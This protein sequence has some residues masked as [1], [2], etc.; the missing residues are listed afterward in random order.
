MLAQ[1]DIADDSQSESEAE[2]K[3][4]RFNDAQ[5]GQLFLLG[6][7]F[8]NPTDE[9]RFFVDDLDILHK[10]AGY[11]IW[12]RQ[13]SEAYDVYRKILD[14]WDHKSGRR[15]ETLDAMVHCAMR[16]GLRLQVKEALAA[17]KDDVSSL[18]DQVN[19]WTTTVAVAEYDADIVPDSEH[20]TNIVYLCTLAEC[21]RHWVMF[22][23]VSD[24]ILSKTSNFRIGAKVRAF[25]LL[26]HEH[27][28]I[29]T[30]S[31]STERLIETL[32]LKL[33]KDLQ[34][35]YTEQ[36]ITT[37]CDNICTDIIKTKDAKETDHSTEPPPHA[38][39]SDGIVKSESELAELRQHF[40]TRFSWLFADNDQLGN[41]LIKQIES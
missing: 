27:D 33:K 37:A 3:E 36:E 6:D 5:P 22:D 40:V 24:R 25:F 2:S 17:L 38:C 8:M 15:R 35:A 41:A 16:A 1:F 12:K 32:M 28:L 18:S 23:K 11:Y 14:N 9:I 10:Q 4:P 20:L 13:Y 7:W 26:K 39:K 29:T 31:D 21:G 34:E 19:L 30:A